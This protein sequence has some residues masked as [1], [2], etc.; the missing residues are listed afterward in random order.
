[1]QAENLR[2]RIYLGK[3]PFNTGAVVLVG[4]DQEN[5]LLVARKIHVLDQY[6]QRY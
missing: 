6:W 1:V 5:A 3:G 2:Y 4:L